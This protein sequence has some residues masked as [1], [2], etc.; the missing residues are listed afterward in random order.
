MPLTAQI[1]LVTEDVQEEESFEC[2][3]RPGA[4]Q[5]IASFT[6]LRPFQ[7]AAIFQYISKD[8]GRRNVR[9]KDQDSK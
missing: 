9:S 4:V 6:I 7:S 3:S 2:G 5:V 8:A 1:C